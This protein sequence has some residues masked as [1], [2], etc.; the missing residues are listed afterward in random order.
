MTPKRLLRP[1]EVQLALQPKRPLALRVSDMGRVP[2][3]AKIQAPVK[4]AGH[5]KQGHDRCRA[6]SRSR[7]APVSRR[8]GRRRRICRRSAG[9]R[10]PD[11]GPQIEG[12][13]SLPRRGKHGWVR[14]RRK[15][16]QHGQVN[17]AARAEI[18]NGFA[19]LYLSECRGVTAT[20]RGPE[21]F[22]G[23]RAFF[24]IGVE[25]FGDG[26]ATTEFRAIAAAGGPAAGG[27]LGGFA[28]FLPY[29]LLEVRFRHWSFSLRGNVAETGEAT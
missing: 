13:R 20:E 4:R 9:Q 6:T 5:P 3:P 12:I 8:G 25:I 15:R 28:V 7:A 21:D 26:V 29:G 14:R 19:G 2:M 11:R 1:L 18:K 17:A 24:R 23:Q 22:F 10:S 27:P 16:I